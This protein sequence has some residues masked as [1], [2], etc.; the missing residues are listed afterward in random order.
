MANPMAQ[1]L[2]S[3]PN[4]GALERDSQIGMADLA[5]R[6]QMAQMLM[7]QA[8]QQPQAQMVGGRYIPPNP[9]QVLANA[10]SGLSGYAMA[11]DNNKQAAD[12]LRQQDATL[13]AQFG[14]GSPGMGQ[15][16][17]AMQQGAMPQGQPAMASQSTFPLLP[18]MSAEQSYTIARNMGLPAYLKLATEQSK[19]V[20]VSPGGMLI[21]PATGQPMFTAPQ[22]GMQTGFDEQGNAYVF[23][24]PG[25]SDI[26]AQRIAAEEA[27]RQKAQAERDI[28]T[29]N[30]PDGSTQQMTR[31]AA[32]QALGGGVGSTPP[33][34]VLE[35]RSDLPRVEDESQRIVQAIEGILSHPGLKGSVGMQ[36]G[37]SMIPGTDEA[38]FVA[39]HNQLRGQ[40]FLQGFQSLKG[41]GAI[42]EKEGQAAEQAIARLSRTQSEAEYR[43]ALE[44]MRQIATRAAER[45]REK[46]RIGESVPRPAQSQDQ[47]PSV[48]RPTS[49]QEYN[50]I[51]SG[52][53]F[54]APD[55]TL[56]RKP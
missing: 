8:Q 42:T 39:R 11:Q 3:G 17:Q 7:Q 52:T 48:A 50:S 41:G 34:S 35:A 16:P 40:V 33:K 38:S 54:Y 19:P 14:I 46:A 26:N 12:L 30:M 24:V 23:P 51:P 28:V 32:T 25:Y 10:F 29:V 2:R 49:A 36:F 9:G 47:A 45:A 44:E 13:A 55:G 56:R 6:Q 43:Q 20:S 27:A 4:M 22:D 53:L 18:G 31:E 5:L 15:A 21:N 37:M 1:L